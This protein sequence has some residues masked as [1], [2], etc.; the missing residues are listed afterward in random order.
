MWC[1]RTCIDPDPHQWDDSLFFSFPHVRWSWNKL[2]VCPWTHWTRVTE[3]TLLM[4]WSMTSERPHVQQTNHTLVGFT[5][6]QGCGMF[7]HIVNVEPGLFVSQLIS[8]KCEST[9]PHCI[10]MFSE[11]AYWSIYGRFLFFLILLIWTSSTGESW[12]SPCEGLSCSSHHVFLIRVC[13]YI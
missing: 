3:Q 13:I 12:S 2:I 4:K 10:Y 8:V 11:R 9:R 1:F 7:G 5:E 6:P